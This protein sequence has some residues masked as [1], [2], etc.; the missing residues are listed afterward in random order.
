MAQCLTHPTR[1]HEV[2]GSIPGLAQWVKDL[3]SCGVVH[4]SSSDP[5]LLWLWCRPVAIAPIRPLACEPPCASGTALEKT[6]DTQQ[7]FKKLKNWSSRC[8][9]VV[10]E[11]D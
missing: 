1:N 3:V 4:R 6:K 8:G 2:S 10:N 9:T 5:S 11:S 7:K